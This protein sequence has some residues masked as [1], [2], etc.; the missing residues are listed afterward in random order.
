MRKLL[1]PLLL[2]LLAYAAWPVVS[3]WQLGRAVKARDVQAIA[4]MVDWVI[5]RT[6]IKQTLTAHL[7]IAANS[8][9]AGHLTKAINGT[10]GS[11][12]VDG[13]IEAAI[14]PRTLAGVLAGRSLLD[15]VGLTET[16]RGK[17]PEGVSERD[18][19]AGPNG[20]P[21]TH[22][23]T[24]PWGPRRLRWAYFETPTRFRI[25]MVHPKLPG[26]RIISVLALQGISWRLVDVYT[27]ASS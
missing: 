25:E 21:N 23:N 15:D 2:V 6:N 5:L 18:G 17:S 22:P 3:A 4:S 10:L 9:A 16:R 7:A 12:A 20:D 27:L 1:I 24:H 8:A 26:K 14:T 11:L 19:E 13:I